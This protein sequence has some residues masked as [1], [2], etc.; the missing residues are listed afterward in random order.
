M[1]YGRNI[2]GSSSEI[3]DY[4]RKSSENVW[5]R[6]SGLR[7]TS[8]ESSDV[9]AKCSEIFEKSSKMKL[10]HEISSWTREEKFHI[11]PHPC[12]ILYLYVSSKRFKKQTKITD[13]NL[14]ITVLF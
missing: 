3:F 13:W 10:T 2:I 11:Y 6:S 1:L 4:P 7:S 9:F 5:R 14:Y 8:G 12:H